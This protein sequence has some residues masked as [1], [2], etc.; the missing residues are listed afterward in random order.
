MRPKAKTKSSNQQTHTTRD[1]PFLV[2]TRKRTRSVRPMI[3]DRNKTPNSRHSSCSSHLRTRNALRIRTEKPP[4][5]QFTSTISQIIP[6][7]TSLQQGSIQMHSATTTHGQ[8]YGKLAAPSH[9]TGI[10]S[11]ESQQS[12]ETRS[13]QI[14]T[15]RKDHPQNQSNS[16]L[17]NVR[18]TEAINQ[19]TIFYTPATNYP[20]RRRNQQIH[21]PTPLAP[22][23]LRRPILQQC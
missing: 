8:G 13:P 3:K 9:P 1:N 21:P 12:K 16:K 17:S 15:H 14:P 11:M 22:P 19:L 7:E 5:Q 2:S 23:Q 18:P 6:S 4:C 20:G 10:P